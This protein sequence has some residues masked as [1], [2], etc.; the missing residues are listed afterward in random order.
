MKTSS[1]RLATLGVLL[2]PLTLVA[3]DN[4]D[5]DADLDIV[6][7][8]EADVDLSVLVDALVEAELDDDLQGTGPFTVFAPT[9]EAFDDALTTL[10]LGDLDELLASPDLEEILLFHVVDDEL[11][12]DDLDDGDTVVTLG[13]ETLTVIETDDGIFLDT[14]DDGDGDAEVIETNIDAENGLIH[15]I[16]AVLLPPGL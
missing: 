15:K 5:P 1:W 7:V 16:D 8:A 2:L 9:D 4:D 12:A 11:S 13:G 3:C 10:G 14:D 6:G